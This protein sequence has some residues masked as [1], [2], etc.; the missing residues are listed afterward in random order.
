MDGV[1]VA[2]IVEAAEFCE[3]ILGLAVAGM[4]F[5]ALVL[6][7][8]RA[9]QLVDADHERTEIPESADRPQI[10][11]Y[12]PKRCQTKQRDG[13]PQIVTRDYC[14]TVFFEIELL[15][16]VE[17]W[18]AHGRKYPTIDAPEDSPDIPL[19]M[20]LVRAGTLSRA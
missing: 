6:D 4:I 18:I 19:K 9:S 15:G 11:D 16:F 8:L 10:E 13:D 12:Q 2:A 3:E 20:W 17:F 7:R 14:V 5:E 1:P